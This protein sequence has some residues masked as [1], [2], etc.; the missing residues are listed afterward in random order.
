MFYLSKVSIPFFFLAV[1]DLLY[2]LAVKSLQLEPKAIWITAV[3]GFIAHT[4]MSAMYQIV[5]NSQGKPL[6]FAWLS[7]A[8]LL[9]SFFASL[10]FYSFQWLYGSFVYAITSLLFAVNILLSVRNWQAITVK[11]IGLGTLYFLLASF[12]LLLSEFGFIP[13]ALAV[14]T[15][16]LGF[17]LNVVIGVELAWIPMLYMEPLNITFSKRLFY[18]SLF[19]LPIFLFGF[20]LLDYRLISIASLLVLAFSGYFLYILYSVFSK[21]RMPKE[22]PLVVRYFILALTMLPF[23]LLLGS[24]MAGEGLVSYLI[25]LHFDILIYGFT[26]ITIMGGLSHLYPRI[27]YNWRFSGVQGVSISDLVSENALKRIFVLLPFSLVWMT[28]ADAFGGL[29]AYVSSIPYMVLWLYFLWAV[30]LRGLI[31]KATS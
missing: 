29:L 16:T 4:I 7:Y 11:F 10:L 12:F 1:L 6:R 27:I 18:L 22:I 28:F 25:P 24:V 8:V 2:S 3:F 19:Y 14:H 21:R 17:M 15:L 5:P 26:G 20:Y 23:G 31:Y 9:L 13:L 30:L